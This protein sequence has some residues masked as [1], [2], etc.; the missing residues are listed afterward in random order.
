MTSND[1]I[2]TCRRPPRR[3]SLPVCPLRVLLIRATEGRMPDESA[4]I[5]TR[6]R[7]RET[8]RNPRGMG[9]GGRELRESGF[10]SGSQ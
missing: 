5:L 2:Q 3:L 9:G 6:R 7:R 1:S 4:G 10:K 8:A